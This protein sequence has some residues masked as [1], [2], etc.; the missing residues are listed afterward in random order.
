MRWVNLIWRSVRYF[1]LAVN[2]AYVLGSGMPVAVVHHDFFIARM[3]GGGVR[4]VPCR[5]SPAVA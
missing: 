3:V 2:S 1:A 4:A 5:D